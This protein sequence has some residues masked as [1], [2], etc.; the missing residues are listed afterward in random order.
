MSVSGAPF[1]CHR[2]VARTSTELFLQ[3]ERK[4]VMRFKKLSMSICAVAVG[5]FAAT[6]SAG[7]LGTAF[8]YQGQLKESGRPVN[9]ACD[10]EFGLW[11]AASVGSQI[12]P[13]LPVTVPG[14]Q[15]VNGLFT[16]SLDFG[17]GAFDGDA[18]WLEI[19]VRCPAGVGG[20]A[21]LLGRQELTP[22]PFAI[23]AMNGGGV[24]GNTLDQAYDEG[25]PG[26]GRTI[27]ADRAPVNIAGPDGLTVN[28]DVGIG[29]P[30]PDHKLEV[31]SSGDGFRV[32][33][34]NSWFEMRTGGNS[35][36]SLGDGGGSEAGYIAGRENAAGENILSIAACTDAGSCPSSTTFHQNGNVGIG[37]SNPN[38][39]LHVAG[40]ARVEGRTIYNPGTGPL[41]TAGHTNTVGNEKRM[42]IG[43][44][45]SYPAWGIQYRDL[46]SDNLSA[47]SI[48]FVSG[49]TTKPRVSFHLTTGIMRLFDPSAQATVW[50]S[51]N[52]GG[53]GA[54]VLLSNSAGSSTIELDA[55]ENDDGVF[56]LFDAAGNTAITLHSDS[57][58][59]GGQISMFND[60]GFET[61]EIIAAEAA[62]GNGGQIKLRKADGTTTIELDAEWGAG[63]S[64]RIITG[65][66][67]ITGGG[68]L[69]EQFNVNA[70]DAAPGPGMVVCIDPQN[71]GEL[72]VSQE[73][74]DRTVAGV[75]SGA[76]GVRPG[77]LMGQRGSEADGEHPVAL[78]GRVYVWA[79]ASA[80]PIEPGDMLTT[81]EVPGHAMKVTDFG[82]AQ[83][84]ILGKAM[85]SLASG[86]GLV[87]V[88]VSLQ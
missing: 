52:A 5:S 74:Y 16:V 66:L 12:G 55:D 87:L 82:K 30:T 59:A 10:F 86:K 81:A 75:I 13:L 20:F 76:G 64:G 22:A 15:M 24:G 11:T 68:D 18:R 84:A 21:T 45:E 70:T 42:W 32:G 88:L 23:F 40:N 78:T 80:G 54:G 72:V 43:H 26:A 41:M 69:S 49:D 29:T 44:S 6:L 27:T 25:G 56:R 36:L 17:P 67:Q 62:L 46:A 33:S 35:R 79:D 14:N 58:S 4:E 9:G 37:T 39:R 85:S 60:G 2:S 8:T 53:G 38:Q 71:A 57:A 73:A 51:P 61:V 50:I 7:P 31:V 1:E 3:H 28:G 63:G 77:M 65:V 19:A 34:A 48:E 83:G 47:D